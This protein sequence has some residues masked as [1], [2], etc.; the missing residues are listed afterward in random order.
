VAFELPPLPYPTD[1]LMPHIS[2]T[3]ISF[4]YGKHHAAYVKNLNDL[5]AGTEFAGKSLEDVIT[6]SDGKIFNNAAQIWNHTFYWKGMKPGGG[7][8]PTGPLAEALT[9]AFGSVD[10]FLKTFAA[11]AKAAFGS[12]WTWL[13]KSDA[14]L[15]ITTTANADLPMKH[16][17]TALLTIDVWE[18]AYYLDYQNLRPSY[19]DAFLEHLVNW[20]F[21][22]ANLG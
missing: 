1:A 14:G 11:E 7:G 15:A 3:T 19:V 6:S 17:Q 18:H 5:V 10:E 21:V 20:D 22:A 4:H 8:A 2:E 16:G 9:T 12:G 13:V